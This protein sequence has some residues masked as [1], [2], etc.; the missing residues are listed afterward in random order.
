M[1]E[2]FLFILP[3]AL[4][5]LTIGL[6]INNRYEDAFSSFFIMFGCILVLLYR[7]SNAKT[8]SRTPLFSSPGAISKTSYHSYYG[9]ELNFTGRELVAI[10]E[11]RFPYFNILSPRQRTTFINR[12]QKFMAIKI[13]KI[14]EGKG[15]KEMPVLVSAAAIQLTFGLQKYLLPH[16]KFIHIYPREFL[17]VRPVL[18][19]LEG[20]VSGHAI[21][22]SWKHF[23]AGYVNPADGQNLGLHEMAH[24]LYYQT[25]V[26]EEHIDKGFREIYNNFSADGI[27]AYHREKTQEGGLYSAYAE[28]NFQEFWAETAELFFEKPAQLNAAYP[29]LYQIIKSMLNQDPL[30]AAPSMAG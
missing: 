9:N 5:A 3:L 29:H 4:F 11:K 25:F 10:L 1:K 7:I 18:C 30:V 23:L 19:F 8:G 15:F 6:T 2:R 24:A 26:V 14:H 28:K 16:F 21:N 13:F 12:L 17:R 22:M 27:K 20:N